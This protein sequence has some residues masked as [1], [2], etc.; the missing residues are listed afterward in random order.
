MGVFRAID[1]RVFT[2]SF[3]HSRRSERDGLFDDRRHFYSPLDFT[4]Q[5]NIASPNQL[6]QQIIIVVMF[7]SID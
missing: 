2:S 3:V 7:D 5:R 1:F 4:D 6:I